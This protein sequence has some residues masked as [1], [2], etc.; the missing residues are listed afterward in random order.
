LKSILKG[1][2]LEKERSEKTSA[3][4]SMIKDKEKEMKTNSSLDNK[5]FKLI[6]DKIEDKLR[7][8]I[9]LFKPR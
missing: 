3:S 6:K 1:S 2:I 9:Q 5:S 8:T 7:T 4:Q